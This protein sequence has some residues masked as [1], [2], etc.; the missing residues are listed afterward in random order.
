[1]IKINGKEIAEDKIFLIEYLKS[2]NY[3]TDHI[4]IE[5]NGSIIPKNK[6]SEAVLKNGDKAEIVNFVGGG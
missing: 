4:A 3:N 1:M 2:N 5:L 6:Y